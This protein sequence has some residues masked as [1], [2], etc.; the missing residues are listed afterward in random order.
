MALAGEKNSLKVQLKVK[1]IKEAKQMYPIE[2][3]HHEKNINMIAFNKAGTVFATCSADAKVNVYNSI[4]NKMV[5]QFKLPS[6]I[7]SI[8]FTE[9]DRI[10]ASSLYSHI[11]IINPFVLEN[12]I[13]AIHL[14][15]EDNRI[16][17]T[18]LSL[19]GKSL[20]FLFERSVRSKSEQIVMNFDYPKLEELIPKTN[21]E[22]ASYNLEGKALWE[23]SDRNLSNFKFYVIEN[24]VFV[25][26]DRTLKKFDV[27]KSLDEA[28]DFL[29][30]D[31][32]VNV[33]T[34]TNSPRFEFLFLSYNE[35]VKLVDPEK[36]VIVRSIETKHPVNCAQMSPL[37]YSPTNPK[38]HLIFGGGIE[39]VQQATKSEGGNQIFIYN[40][41]TEEKIGEIR[42][43][44]GNINWI[45]LFKDG[46]GIITAGE[47]GI[48]RIYRL[49]ESY[50]SENDNP[51]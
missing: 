40:P 44:Y 11:Y 22:K 34:I 14:E 13:S 25:I 27:K 45:A 12:P 4:N 8:I 35:G 16:L 39:A 51:Q 42:S 23:L 28:V 24:I 38:F 17:C 49:D 29:T 36:M 43:A 37:M 20:G 10:I 31:N 6:A 21:L 30:F 7:K 32:D 33:N 46:S 19:S 15:M 50:Y 18:D 3:R 9:S 26:S 2:V 41:A 48:C 5:N 1:E 47:E